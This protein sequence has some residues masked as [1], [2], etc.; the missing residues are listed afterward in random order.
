[1]NS[2]KELIINKME[3]TNTINEQLEKDLNAKD[4]ENYHVN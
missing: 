3:K 1:M 2:Y 4:S